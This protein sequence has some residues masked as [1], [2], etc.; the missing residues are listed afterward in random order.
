MSG[1]FHFGFSVRD[2][3]VGRL[4]AS[5]IHLAHQAVTVDGAGD[6]LAE[7]LVPK[8]FQLGRI[9]DGFARGVGAGVLVEPEEV[10]VGA[11]A[12]IEELETATG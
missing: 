2:E 5:A 12:E 4:R 3:A 8:P 7:L 10:A 9:D 11:D 1:L 6:R